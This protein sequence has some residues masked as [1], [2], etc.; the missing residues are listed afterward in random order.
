MQKALD[1]LR[2]Q[3]FEIKPEDEARLSPLP[4]GH[5]NVLGN[6]SFKLED[7]VG[8]GLLRPLNIVEKNP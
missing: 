3:N 8:G 1:Y 7:K 4:H 2:Q 6:Y 5:I